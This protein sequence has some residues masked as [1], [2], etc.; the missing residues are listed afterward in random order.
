MRTIKMKMKECKEF[1]HLQLPHDLIDT[2]K[3]KSEYDIQ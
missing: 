2:E 3:Y 1:A